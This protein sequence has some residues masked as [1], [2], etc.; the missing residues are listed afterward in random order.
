MVISFL[1]KSHAVH[2]AEC[3]IG[4]AGVFVLDE[5]VRG[6]EADLRAGMSQRMSGP[7][8]RI[9]RRGPWPRMFGREAGDKESGGRGAVS[10]ATSAAATA[11][12]S[13]VVALVVASV[14][15]SSGHGR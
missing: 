10:A 7:C 14:V 1:P 4:I 11:A 12:R 2:V 15:A 3:C 13:A 9:R 6:A 5:G 8:A